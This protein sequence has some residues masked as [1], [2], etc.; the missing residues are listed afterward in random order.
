MN[1]LVDH[2]LPAALARF[3]ESQGHQ[4]RHVRELGMTE[5]KDISIWQTAAAQNAVV[6]S[7][8]EDFYYLAIRPGESGRLIWVRMGN[9]RKLALIES[10]TSHL[11]QIIQALEAGTRIVEIR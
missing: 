3:L 9:C 7:K 8:D 11:P 10:F 2:Q 6:I 1:F 5:A 4:A